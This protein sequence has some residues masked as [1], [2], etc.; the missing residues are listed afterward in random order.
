MTNITNSP[1]ETQQIAAQLAAELQGGEVI[2]LN[3]EL[4]AGKTTFVQ[5]FVQ[6]LGSADPVRSPTFT[7]M[8]IYQADHPAIKQIIHLDF[9]RL[10]ETQ[11]QDLGLDEWLGRRDTVII[12][13]WPPA[14]LDWAGSRQIKIQLSIHSEQT[15][16]IIVS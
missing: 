1:A 2:L 10:A 9:Y 13:E 5:G 11:L 6:A 4:G 15:R 3:G 14:G 16:Q 7:I 12:A 8:N